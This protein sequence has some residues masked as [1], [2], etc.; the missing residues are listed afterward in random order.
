M[1]PLEILM[2]LL[3]AVLAGAVQGLTGFGSGIV[4][5]VF[6][7]AMIGVLP[8]A[9]INQ[10]VGVFLTATMVIKY[11]KHVS[12]KKLVAPFLIYFPIY[13][14][15][16]RM[17]TGLKI[18]YLKPI[19]GLFLVVL[20]IYFIKLAEKLR[21]PANNKTMLGCI[22]LSAVIDAFFAMG[23]PPQVVYFMAATERKEQYLGT[24]Q[25]FM[26]M[27][28]LYGSSM[29]ALNGMFTSTV[30]EVLGI[31]LIGIFLGFLVSVRIV[32]HLN[33]D[34]LR[35]LVYY[36]IGIAGAIIFLTNIL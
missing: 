25:A 21:I 3:P 11:R 1:D 14:I 17:V 2:F 33:E 13:L 10:A 23:G 35:T 26:F 24:I 34:K 7:P 36:F 28:T 8:S 29:R 5:S 4:L 16:L 19:L 9:T 15:L 27:T 30:L 6:Y 31:T 32:K 22:S 20:A 12:W 18:H